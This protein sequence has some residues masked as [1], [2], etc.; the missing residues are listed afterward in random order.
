MDKNNPKSL[1]SRIEQTLRNKFAPED[2]QKKSLEELIEEVSVYYQELELQNEELQHTQ[3][4]LEAR[5]RQ[6][7]DLY[8]NA[9]IGYATYTPDGFLLNC[10]L[11]FRSWTGLTRVSE[12][13]IKIQQLLTPESQDT[14][15]FYLNRVINQE[16]HTPC[17]VY[18]KGKDHPIPVRIESNLLEDFS[19]VHHIR[20]AFI[21]I[22]QQIEA[23]NRVKELVEELK[24]K[25]QKL[26]EFQSRLDTALQVG[27]IFWWTLELPSGPFDFHPKKAENLGYAA[28]NF[29]HY[30]HFTN[31]VHPEDSAHMFQEMRSH[32]QG[33][34]PYYKS[35]YRIRD[36][37]G[38]YRWYYDFGA[39]THRDPQTKAVQVQGVTMDITQQKEYEIELGKQLEILR[40]LIA[41]LKFR[42]KTEEGFMEFVLHEVLKISGSK[43][44]CLYTYQTREGSL[45]LKTIAC[46]M[47]T[48]TPCPSPSRNILS[49]LMSGRYTDVIENSF[50]YI[51]I[52]HREDFVGLLILPSPDLTQKDAFLLKLNIL[53]RTAWEILEEWKSELHR[54][55]YFQ[56]ILGIQQPVII[57]DRSGIIEEVNPAFLRLYGYEKEEVLGQNPRILNPGVEVY[58]NLGYTEE[59]YK[60]LFSN[61]WRSILNPTGG[62]WEGILINRKKN[63]TLVWVQLYISAIRDINGQIQHFIALPVDISI[64]KESEYK[65]R[66]D[67][68]RTI[69]RLSE[70][71]DNETGNHMRRVGLYARLLAKGLGMPD[72]FCE[73]MEL[74]APMHDI[75]KVGISDTILLVNRPLSKDEYEEIK[76]HTLL[77]HNIVRDKEELRTAADIILYHHERWDGKGYPMG[78]AEEA[79]PLSAR[80]TAI[81]D[82]Y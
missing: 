78:L 62:Q 58:K 75:G 73:E 54:E 12:G 52:Y 29:T 43:R 13:K 28:K 81:A 55:T 26:Q 66:I 72:K 14:F 77:G 80:I 69:A 53:L 3:S 50:W 10:N 4:Q 1:K 41:L 20:S 34:M 30:T 65:S 32:L 59:E 39:V 22:S 11:L 49:K 51:P 60:E 79:I 67:L 25:N 31:L 24:L 27:K 15:Y 57:T 56:A 5:T 37:N 40:S 2:L 18:L 6:L 16:I 61:L 71:R 46:R 36:V 44:G 64:L 35:E 9:P 21:D 38:N 33:K 17:T 63:G 7:E 76:K 42:I 19:T 23:E 45:S 70:L 82:V 68:Y 48:S 47:E 8:E 74:F